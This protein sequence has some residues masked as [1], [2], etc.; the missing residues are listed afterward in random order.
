MNRE[1][2]KFYRYWGKASS[3]EE[4]EEASYHLLAYH[5]LDV[6]AVGYCLLDPEK[7][8]CCS[9]ANG[10]QVK[11]EWLR[12]WFCFCLMLHDLGKFFRS[13]QNLVPDQSPS[14]VSYSAR[15]IYRYRHDSLGFCLWKKILFKKLSDVFPHKIKTDISGWL[16]VVCGHHGQPPNKSIRGLGQFLEKDDE[17]AAEQFVRE[18]AR[19][20]LPDI[21]PIPEI[22]ETAFKSASWQLAGLAVLAD[23]LG[24]DQSVFTYK[25]DEQALDEYWKNIALVK[26]KEVL[27]KAPFQL[28]PIEPYQ[29][30]QQQFPF[31]ETSTPLQTYSQQVYIAN[32]P[33]LFLLEDVTGAG[34]TEAAMVLVHRLMA[35]GLADGLYVGLPSMATANAM[36]ER[37]GKS[38]RAL[39]STEARPSLVLAHGASQLSDSF[40]DAIALSEQN[41][42]RDYGQGDITATAYCN[43]WLADSRKKAMLADVGI[44][45]IDQALLAVLPAKH[46]SLRLLGLTGKVLLVDEVHAYDPYMQSLLNALLKAH[47]SQGGSA[48]LLSATLPE[49]MRAQLLTSYAEGLGVAR[50]VLQ[51]QDYPLVTRFSG[52]DFN[53][54]PVATRPSVERTVTVKRLS[55]EQIAIDL[56]KDTVAANRCICWIRNTVKDARAAYEK[57]KQQDW[58]EGE[59]LTLFH[60]RFA[61]TDRQV[62]EKDVLKRFGKTSTSAQRQAQVLIATQVVEQSLDLDFDVLISDLAPIDLLIQRAGRLQRHCREND[63]NCTHD[64]NAQDQRDAPCLHLLSPDPNKVEDKDWLRKLLPGTQAVYSNVGQLWLTSRVLLDKNCFTMPQ[65]ARHLIESVYGQETDS[66]IPKVLE[67]ASFEAEAE[68]KSQ[69]GMGKFNQLNMDDG[70]T[71]ESAAQSAG[72]DDDVN[73]PTRLSGDSVSIILAQTEKQA[74]QKTLKPYAQHEKHGWSM[75]KINIPKHEWEKARE[76]IS[77][78]WLAVVDQLKLDQSFLKWQEI[79]PLTAKTEHFYHPEDG[80]DLDRKAQ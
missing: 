66:D 56:I 17:L 42:D 62:I 28:Q 13:F 32:G 78:E 55:D 39:Y 75:S 49:K 40:Q 45:T 15:C 64:S 44:G 79:L 33:Q 41:P 31:I 74:E 7:A 58:V 19:L 61:M 46:Q 4:E 53:E 72:W 71:L 54:V 12:D 68:Q 11:P 57:L 2:L 48:I 20:W 36:F 70:Y 43:A 21:T 22:S 1:H 29:S 23:W 38:Y 6:A 10:L 37:L 76:F 77:A 9:L 16:E 65:N 47:A 26:A 5:C 3:K 30:I 51:K 18:I 80:W 59:N 52:G 8:L 14:L 24:S 34:K 73:I 63:G 69:Q 67:N 60:S 27:E 25:A 35:A 50:P